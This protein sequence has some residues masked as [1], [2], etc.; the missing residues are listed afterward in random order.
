M[1]SILGD[2]TFLDPIQVNL[3]DF[4]IYSH[5]Y[6]QFLAE[7]Q[8]VH[9][10]LT[11][12]V[13]V[14]KKDQVIFKSLA[15]P[16]LEGNIA[17][18]SS[19]PTVSDIVDFVALGIAILA[20]LAFIFMFFKVRKILAIISIL[21]QVKQVKSESAL[22][23]FVYINLFNLLPHHQQSLSL[24]YKNFHGTMHQFCY[25]LL[26]SPFYLYFLCITG[27]QKET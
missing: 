15:E 14:A 20:I 24:Y 6:N 16:L 18:D 26:S 7:D 9:L 1:K 2:T 8:K 27:F 19:C 13:N 22:P 5:D 10:N 11:K 23:S 21:Q 4:K 3:P 25:H 17:I 12:M